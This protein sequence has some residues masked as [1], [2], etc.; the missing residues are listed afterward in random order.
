MYLRGQ[1]AQDVVVLLLMRRV[2]STG[3]VEKELRNRQAV[4]NRTVVL[5]REAALEVTGDGCQCERIEVVFNRQAGDEDVVGGRLDDGLVLFE[6]AQLGIEDRR[7]G[8]VVMLCEHRK[9]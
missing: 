2:D 9:R 6:R 1:R 4:E 8:G 3:G 5:E 7:V